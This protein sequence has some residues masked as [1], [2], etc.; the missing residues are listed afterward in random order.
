MFISIH[1]KT[2]TMRKFYSMIRSIGF[3]IAGMLLSSAFWQT[4]NAACSTRPFSIS[5]QEVVRAYI[6]YYGRVSDLSGL[7]FWSDRLERVGSLSSI[8]SAF[9]DSTE[10]TLEF[11]HL[12]HSELV[13]NLFLQAFNR[14][15]DT[16]GLAFYTGQL[17]TGQRTLQSIALDI[18]NGAQND[19]L[20]IITHRVSVARHFISK[21][22]SISLNWHA[23]ASS[24]LD[25]VNANPDSMEDACAR[26][27]AEL[28]AGNPGALYTISGSAVAALH[29]QSDG[30]VNDIN[31]PFRENDSASSVQAIPVTG[32][33]G[34]Y[35]NQPL[36]GAPGRSYNTG[37]SEDY[38]SV[39]L[40][41]GQF[42]NL[43][44]ADPLD[45]DLD[46]Y[47]YD[48]NGELAGTSLGTGRN[49]QIPI[50]TAG[51]YTLLIHAHA[52][53]SNYS[54]TI[55][56]TP[57]SQAA[58]KHILRLEHPILPG[59]LIARFTQPAS[60][61]SSPA[62]NPGAPPIPTTS[63]AQLT[64]AEIEEKAAE[65]GLSVR[66]GQPAAG[67]L[68]GI[69]QPM[70]AR[71]L[72]R[73]PGNR[74]FSPADADTMPAR[75][76]DAWHTIQTIKQ[77][78]RRSDID[79]AEPNYRL[80]AS[81]TP[82]DPH[83]RR[84]W[85]YPLIQLEDAWDLST[86]DD[87]VIVAVI[88]TGVL[89]NH[90][91]L[92]GRLVAGYDFISDRAFAN[93][94]DGIDANPDDPG[95][96]SNPDGSGSFHG[97]H[98]A[99]TVAA[100][101]NNARGGAGVMWSGRIM[102]LRV[103]GVGGGSGYDI[104]QAIRY[105]A[106]LSNDSGLVPSAP[107]SIINMSLGGPGYSQS[108]QDTLSAARDAGVIV[109]AAA[110]NESTSRRS[111]PAAY[112]GVVAVSA[113]D[114]IRQLADYSNYGNWIDVA[115]PGGD[116][117]AD[118]DG[119]GYGDGV[120]S[121]LGDN[122]SNDLRYVYGYYQGTSMAAPHLAGVA[123]LMKSIHPGLTPSGFDALLAGAR[124]TEDLGAAGKDND[125]G[126]GLIN[127]YKAMIAAQDAAGG[128]GEARPVL[129]A[130]PNPLNFAATTEQLQLSLIQS[131]EGAINVQL[132]PTLSHNWIAVTPV[133][134]DAGNIGTYRV[135]VQR[136]G[137]NRG[138]HSG[139]ITF[140]SDANS[141]SLPVYMQ[142]LQSTF[143][144][145][146][147]Y[148]YFLLVDNDLNTIASAEAASN[149]GRYDFRFSD[150]PNGEYRIF[151]GTDMDNDGFICDE[152]EACGAYPTL[153]NPQILN[154]RSDQTERNFTTQFE[155][156]TP[157]TATLPSLAPLRLQH[158]N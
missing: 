149:Q 35:I 137:L 36:S 147:G 17:D 45:A 44:I 40:A 76:A 100:A 67:M 126:H 132:P 87:G 114:Q 139:S 34:G 63:G 128:A 146:T 106:G 127:A 23:L 10:F 131:G 33:V 19:D 110:G 72:P 93:D 7:E 115:A 101:T 16:T 98:V 11:A 116:S 54:L 60:R 15:A 121:T 20:T 133:S 32:T 88:D 96:Q 83:Y 134:T 143:H 24:V 86:G 70:A 48:A 148:Q 55:G 81:A 78:R 79:Y 38:Y 47:L 41:S 5:E 129:D 52:G 107:A 62:G 142:V 111:Y 53:A 144:S 46:L 2:I 113:V 8:I 104:D 151:G 119:D 112:D 25:S 103:L 21:L 152:G 153:S 80:Q 37:D 123:G 92:Q 102:P 91:D 118:R 150:V 157:E 135:T 43:G 94:G 58:S 4:A 120:L 84:Q 69:D 61:S 85:H 64:L 89:L 56:F 18:L 95:D 74:P 109:I 26:I 66:R 27:D 105:A 31:A 154:V 28:N 136:D 140:H 30:D 77:L 12:D 155:L 29:N 99:G 39:D 9:G 130:S 14:S 50:T 42:V 1:Q 156:A 57:L 90:P 82:D 65:T 71:R 125:F 97:T 145:D 51:R 73:P 6:A 75:Y 138:S 108:A 13:D 59:Q 22:E 124:I 68:F 49:E 122:A 3:L 117:G 158:S 141:I